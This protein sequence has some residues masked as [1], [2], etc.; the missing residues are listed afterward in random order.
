MKSNT[1]A[2]IITARYRGSEQSAGWVGVI[3]P[4]RMNYAG[5]IPRI[6]YFAT[7]IGR[8]MSAIDMN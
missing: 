1:N 4:T 2:S 7:A 5:I 8:L 3:G 6:E